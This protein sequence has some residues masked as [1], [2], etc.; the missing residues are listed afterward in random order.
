MFVKWTV[1]CYF[2]TE[3]EYFKKYFFFFSDIS[4]SYIL[5]IQISADDQKLCVD[6][7]VIISF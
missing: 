2:N 4:N 5:Y 7:I 3:V 1:C 6:I